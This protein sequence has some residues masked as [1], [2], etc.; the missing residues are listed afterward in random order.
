MKKFKTFL[1]VLIILIFLGAEKI[2]ANHLNYALPEYQTYHWLDNNDQDLNWDSNRVYNS[3]GQVSIRRIYWQN[4]PAG[5]GELTLRISVPTGDNFELV[6]TEDSSKRISFSV[7]VEAEGDV[8]HTY[9]TTTS[10]LAYTVSYKNDNTYNFISLKFN[11]PEGGQT[12]LY[13]TYSNFFMIEFVDN[14]GVI[15][16]SRAFPIV[17]F[18]VKP[19]ASGSG[20]P[21]NFFFV[22]QYPTAEGIDV[23]YLNNNKSGV[24]TVGA[25]SFMSIDSNANDSFKIKIEPE[26]SN[27]FRFEKNNGQGSIPYYITLPGRSFSSTNSAVTIPI[28]NKALS[29]KWQEYMEIGI[30]RINEYNTPLIGGDYSSTIKVTLIKD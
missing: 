1:F 27:Q 29:N 8:N 20:E 30:T 19:T 3:Y 10:P 15:V 24:L 16:D 25:V 2:I 21:Q 26:N 9:E 22:E 23:I 4:L 5:Y 12:S 13:G 6:N 18:Y 14:N 7:K 28:E 17:A 11:A